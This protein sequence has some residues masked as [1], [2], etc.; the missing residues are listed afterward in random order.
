MAGSF[1]A[2]V[3]QDN[4]TSFFQKEQQNA[5]HVLDH[6]VSFLYIY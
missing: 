3:L 4:V 5:K 6:V 2:G 1:V